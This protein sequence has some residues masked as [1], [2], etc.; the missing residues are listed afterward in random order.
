MHEEDKS[1]QAKSKIANM[2]AECLG[3]LGRRKPI[4]AAAAYLGLTEEIMNDLGV[5][6]AQIQYAAVA[7]SI[8]GEQYAKIN[9]V[10]S[11]DL[12]VICNSIPTEHQEAAVDFAAST[13]GKLDACLDLWAT[14][15]DPDCGIDEEERFQICDAFRLALG[16]VSLIRQFGYHFNS[17]NMGPGG[18]LVV[19]AALDIT[20]LLVEQDRTGTAAAMCSNPTIKALM[21]FVMSS[22]AYE[23]TDE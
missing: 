14:L 5:P 7:R 19:P 16:A 22:D 8:D 20:S 17:D 23:D 21:E 6:P 3:L 11:V 13:F 4:E 18:P 12:S 1:L 9:I 2:A 10:P 15:E